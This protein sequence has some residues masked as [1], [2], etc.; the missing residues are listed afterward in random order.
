MIHPLEVT[1]P[2]QGI[3]V[4]LLTHVNTIKTLKLIL[5]ETQKI[6]ANFDNQLLVFTLEIS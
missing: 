3:R 4:T 6:S 1:P 2:N 5:M